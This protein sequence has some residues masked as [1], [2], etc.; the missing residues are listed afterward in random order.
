MYLFCWF[1]LGLL[2]TSTGQHTSNPKKPIPA[3][4]EPLSI[5]DRVEQ[6]AGPKYWP[7]GWDDSR[8]GW[9]G[10]KADFE[11]SWAHGL[12][13]AL[14]V[15]SAT[16]NFL[17]DSCTNVH[18]PSGARQNNSLLLQEQCGKFI[19]TK[20]SSK[21][22]LLTFSGK[23]GSLWPTIFLKCFDLHYENDFFDKL[24]RFFNTVCIVYKRKKGM[25][26]WSKK[27]KN[28]TCHSYLLVVGFLW[29]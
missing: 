9:A 29:P 22:Q 8:M 28:L 7:M 5:R 16:Y 23:P 3:L 11:K 12:A 13:H 24:F 10:L 4:K 25:Y 20:T 19:N 21:F 1:L 2:V 26:L 17:Y 18:N 6:C 27:V 15:F 14:L